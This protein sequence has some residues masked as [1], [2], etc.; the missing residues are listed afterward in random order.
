MPYSISRVWPAMAGDS[1]RVSFTRR[2]DCLESMTP[3]ILVGHVVVRMNKCLV[4]FLSAP[5]MLYAS[6]LMRSLRQALFQRR[7]SRCLGLTVNIF[8][9][10]CG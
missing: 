4:C 7:S 9:T 2:M 3:S 6:K 8:L 1:R 10:S 5:E